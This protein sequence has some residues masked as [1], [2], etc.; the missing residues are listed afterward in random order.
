MY[1]KSFEIRWNDLDANGHLGNSSYVEYMSH[2]RMSFFTEQ[3]FGIEF[4]NSH[5]LGPIVLN[6]HI[7]Y[8]KEFLRNDKVFVTLEVSGISENSQFT[9]IEHN[10]YNDKGDHMAHAEML[11][12]FI[13]LKTRKLGRVPEEAI[14]KINS[15]PKS[16]DF[17]TLTKEDTRKYG[18]RPVSID[19]ARLG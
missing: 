15:F 2:T 10:F 6:E 4:M 3:D 14:K 12:S 19:S 7:F 18:K 9:K 1:I 5:D 11:F 17:K 13:N 16:K 8:F